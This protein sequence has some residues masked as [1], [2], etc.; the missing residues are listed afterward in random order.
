MLPEE[1]IK[2]SKG[3]REYMLTRIEKRAHDNSDVMTVGARWSRSILIIFG[4]DMEQLKGTLE[5]I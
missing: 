4:R 1:A 2:M 5:R 3:D